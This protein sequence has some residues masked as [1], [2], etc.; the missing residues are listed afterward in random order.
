MMQVANKNT[1]LTFG[2]NEIGDNPATVTEASKAQVGS[3]WGVAHDKTREK[4][5]TSAFLRRHAGLGPN[6]LGA[7]YSTDVDNN[8]TASLLVKIPYVGV[9]DEAARGLGNQDADTLDTEAFGK[10]GKVGLG[11][12]DISDDDKT[13]YVT[14]LNNRKLYVVDIATSAITS[15][16]DVPNPGCTGGTFRPFAVTYNDGVVYVGGVCDGG[17]S[18]GTDTDI[19]AYV[20]PFDPDSNSFGAEVLS[21]DLNYL[22]T[23]SVHTG[24]AVGAASETVTKHGNIFHRWQDNYSEV[25][26]NTVNHKFVTH[27][28]PM[29]T[30]I[31]FLAD[32]SMIVTLADRTGHQMSTGNL[33]PDNRRVHVFA[34][35][36]ILKASFSG[37]M[38]TI[39]DHVTVKDNTVKEFFKGDQFP[40]HSHQETSNG[41]IGHLLGSEQLFLT[42]MDPTDYTSGGVLR[43]QTTDGNRT[44]VL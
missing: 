9:I 35:G 43:L 6:G 32:N 41:G 11:D 15:S 38:W 2:Y 42:V 1:L 34:G 16:H 33:L 27:P 31:E 8:A 13:L 21:F 23:G 40:T 18:S 7:I 12:I 4:L 28:V 24:N 20:Y 14:N 37:G 5:Y 36:D 30:D 25:E 22:H 29:L 3:V 17:A 26:Y 19:A 44:M 39:E 10:V